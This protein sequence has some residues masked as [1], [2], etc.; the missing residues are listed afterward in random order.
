E[1]GIKL[2]LLYHMRAI[3]CQSINGC[4]LAIRPGDFHFIY[5]LVTQ[6][7]MLFFRVDG[8]IAN[9]TMD[10]S[11]DFQPGRGMKYY[12]CAYGV[13]GDSLARIP[14]KLDFNPV[15]IIP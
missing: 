10:F 8:H 13:S 9:R 12:S 15:G 5:L 11:P 14:N 2:F 4:L 6:T 1:P 3:Q 7:D